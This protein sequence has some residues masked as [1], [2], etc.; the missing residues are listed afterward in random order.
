[1][2]QSYTFLSR[3]L[4]GPSM[5]KPLK[6]TGLYRGIYTGIMEKKMESTML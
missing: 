6:I 4:R 5:D 1:M 3:Q 2:V